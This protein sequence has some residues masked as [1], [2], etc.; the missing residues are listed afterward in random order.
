[1]KTLILRKWTRND[2]ANRTRRLSAVQISSTGISW[3]TL[4]DN[5]EATN[6]HGSSPQILPRLYT[7]LEVYHDRTSNSNV[8]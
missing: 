5:Q 4:W 7:I 3:T 6:Y 1:M 8:L 2:S